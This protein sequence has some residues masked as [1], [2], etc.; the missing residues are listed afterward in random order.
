MGS[1]R[2]GGVECASWDGPLAVARFPTIE[3]ILTV[4]FGGVHQ[5][6]GGFC[7]FRGF[8]P[9]GGTGMTLGELRQLGTD[10]LKVGVFGN[11]CATGFGGNSDAGGQVRWFCDF[12]P[13]QG[14]YGWPCMS[15]RCRREGGRR[16]RQAKKCQDRR[17]Q[18]HEKLK[19]HSKSFLSVLSEKIMF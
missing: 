7:R 5:L 10:G 18:R 9:N 1:G 16:R 6:G 8:R 2:Q 3:E 15:C 13:G 19:N 12:R 14:S 11:S 4:F 17:K